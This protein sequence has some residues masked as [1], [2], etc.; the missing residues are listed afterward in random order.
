M[1]GLVDTGASCLCID[2]S[3]VQQLTLQPT[4]TGQMISPTTGAIPKD[5]PV[6]DISIK[7]PCKDLTPLDFNSVPAMESILLNQGF[8]VLIGR[9]ILSRCLLIYDGAAQIFTLAF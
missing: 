4:G 8:S 3:V 1:L 7:I 9:D 5:V 2:P 6:Y